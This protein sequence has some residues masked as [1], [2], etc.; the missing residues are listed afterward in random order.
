MIFRLLALA[1][2]TGLLVKLDPRQRVDDP[3][4]I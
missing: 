4:L 2:A 3:G 1:Y